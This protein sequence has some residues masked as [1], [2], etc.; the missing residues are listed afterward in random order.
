MARKLAPDNGHDEEVARH[1]ARAR[2]LI[3]LAQA[4]NTDPVASGNAAQGIAGADMVADPVHTLLL[5]DT[6]QLRA[7]SGRARCRYHGGKKDF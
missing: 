2:Q 7:E 1:D 3:E 5:S 4:C 6:C